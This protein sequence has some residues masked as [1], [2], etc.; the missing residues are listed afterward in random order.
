LPEKRGYDRHAIQAKVWF[1]LEQD[2]KKTISGEVVDISFLGWGGLLNENIDVGTLIEF[3]LSVDFLEEHLL[4][5][6]QIVHVTELNTSEGKSFR[7]GVKF[8][9]V[10][11]EIV[12][13]FIQI[14][15]RRIDRELREAIEAKRKKE[16]TGPKDVGAF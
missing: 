9:E 4:G 1:S 14:N 16:Q 13:D 3:D 11:S 2:T 15:K 12:L 6:G 5:K 8:I 7:V 10:K